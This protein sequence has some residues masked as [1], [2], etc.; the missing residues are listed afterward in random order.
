MANVWLSCA[1]GE[2]A[3][4]DADSDSGSGV[5]VTVGSQRVQAPSKRFDDGVGASDG[6]ATRPAQPT[7]LV[8]TACDTDEPNGTERNETNGRRTHGSSHCAAGIAIPSSI[9]LPCRP[10]PGIG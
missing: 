3:S 7:P 10:S 8:T 5:A 4:S 9:V 2:G 6:G 1:N